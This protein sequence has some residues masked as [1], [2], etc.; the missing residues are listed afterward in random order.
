MIDLKKFYRMIQVSGDDA[1]TFL[2]GQLT[3]D[4]T[5]VTN[6][7][8]AFAAHC[9]QKGRMVSL[10]FVIHWQTAFYLIMPK[11]IIEKAFATLQR[12]I[13]R[14]KVTLTLRQD[15]QLIGHLNDTLLGSKIAKDAFRV[16]Q[17]KQA[18]MVHVPGDRILVLSIPSTLSP[19]PSPKMGEG[20]LWQLR[21]IANNMP[22][23]TP[24]T[25]EKFIPNEINLAQHDGISFEKGC[26]I[27]QEIVARLH[28]LGK[29]KSGLYQV[30][31]KSQHPPTPGEA[32]HNDQGKTIGNLV[33]AVSEAEETVGLAVLQNTALDQTDH[34]KIGDALVTIDR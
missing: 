10:M 5:K 32:I 9:N 13:F 17:D 6:E 26:Y 34:L 1:K 19:A 31:I 11:A 3:C 7:R 30:T 14:S 2:Q 15:L 20:N 21:D 24:E 16:I 8:A 22:W 27:G 12:Y 18:C 23:L 29:L 28:Y 33:C 4:M 25:L